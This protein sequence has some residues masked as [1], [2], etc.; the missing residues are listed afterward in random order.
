[1]VALFFVVTAEEGVFGGERKNGFFSFLD[2]AFPAVA[3]GFD[4]IWGNGTRFGRNGEGRG[5]VF[6]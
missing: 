2:S 5:E 3:V 1:M 4:E 6:R